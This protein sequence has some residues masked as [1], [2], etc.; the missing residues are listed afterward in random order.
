METF[1]FI[2]LHKLLEM[3][4]KQKIYSIVSYNLIYKRV[5]K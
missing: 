1:T 5:Y 4:F 2:G 3:E